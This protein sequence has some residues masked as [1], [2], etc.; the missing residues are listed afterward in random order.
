MVATMGGKK[1]SLWKEAMKTITSQNGT[2]ILT[3]GEC[4][5]NSHIQQ[6]ELLAPATGL[7]LVK[8]TTGWVGY[9][10]R[11]SVISTRRDTKHR[12]QSQVEYLP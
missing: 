8:D 9:I 3:I 5:R 12:Q 7:L 4:T 2:L 10:Y 1:R 11:N 6:I